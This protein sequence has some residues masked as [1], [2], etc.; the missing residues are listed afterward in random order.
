MSPRNLVW[1]LCI[2]GIIVGCQVAEGLLSKKQGTTY[3]AEGIRINKTFGLMTPE[4]FVE[5]IKSSLNFDDEYLLE[6]IMSD[7][8]LALGGVDFRTVKQR[9]HIPSGQ[10]QLTIHR[11]AWEIAQKVVETDV[12]LEGKK[13]PPR[14]FTE[15]TIAVDR[16]YL[17]DDI[18]LPPEIQFSIKQGDRRYHAQLNELYWRLLSRPP[19][20]AE[21]ENMTK[22]FIQTLASENSA[23]AS[24]KAVLF[25]LLASMEYWNI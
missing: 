7:H 18:R 1:V 11:L 15:V 22:L 21:V 17:P 14:A 2:G 5:N 10:S 23:V 24:W 8:L 3:Q 12:I 20:D 16:P 9:S 25:V 4:Q 6:S 13:E 19:S